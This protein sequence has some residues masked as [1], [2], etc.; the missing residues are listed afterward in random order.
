M[1]WMLGS[2]SPL[3]VMEWICNGVDV[4]VRVTFDSDGVDM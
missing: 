2:G 3:T 4:G 1:V